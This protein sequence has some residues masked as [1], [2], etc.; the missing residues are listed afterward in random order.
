MD[1]IEVRFKFVPFEPFFSD[2][3]SQQLSEIAFDSF[4]VEGENLFAYIPREKFSE[5]DVKAVISDFFV[6]DVNITYNTETIGDCNW[7]TAWETHQY[8]PIIIGDMCVIHAS[9]HSDLPRTKHEIIIDPNMAFG[10]GA[11]ET[12]NMLVEILLGMDLHDKRTLD[13]GCGTGIL[14]ISMSKSG[15]KSVHAI[16]V[17]LKSVSNTRKNIGLNG[18]S[19]IEVCHGDAQIIPSIGLFDLIVANIHRNIIIDDM[20]IYVNSLSQNGSIIVS[21]FYSEDAPKVLERA[22]SLGLE[23]NEHRTRNGWCVLVFRRCQ[24]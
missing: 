14:S 5:D 13:M 20:E 18:C 16:D 23:L 6:P 22:S 3:L 9:H 19:N 2:L 7:N 15:A 11:H 10:T 24:N 12:T 8:A 1:Y 17:D 4:K 21:G